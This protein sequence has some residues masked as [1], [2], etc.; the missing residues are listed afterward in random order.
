MTVTGKAIAKAF[1][2]YDATRSY[3]TGCS[4]GGQQ[5]LIEAQYYPDDYDGILVGAPVIDRTAG[6]ALA[7]WDL[8]SANLQPG[9]QLSNAK[10]TL[11]H[12]AVLSACAAKG[13]GLA[14]DPFVSD[15]LACTFDPAVLACKGADS[16][17]CLTAGEIQT[18]K[19]FY[20]GPVNSAGRATLLRLA[21][22]KRSARP[23]GW[24]FLETPYKGEA[25]F[26]GLFKWVF[27]VGWNWRDFNFERDMPKVNGVLAPSIL[28]ASKLRQTQVPNSARNL[29]RRQ[30]R[31]IP[32][33]WIQHQKV[34]VAA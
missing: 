34:L 17:D 14:S 7:V 13:N 11:L 24:T 15:P 31:A 19:D 26:D 8:Q 28:E 32:T 5:G 23:F 30:N 16:D 27:G 10:L 1:Y 4:T 22:R 3:F 6:H 12:N 9:R 2:G 18:A 29:R 33:P 20:S 21:P 25:P